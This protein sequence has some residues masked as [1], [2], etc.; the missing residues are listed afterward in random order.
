MLYKLMPI[1]L[2]NTIPNTTM[3]IEEV[4]PNEFG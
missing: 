2:S 3:R 1:P 4:K